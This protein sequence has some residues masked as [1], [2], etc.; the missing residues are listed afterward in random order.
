[1]IIGILGKAGSGKDTVAD[2]LVN[3][4]NLV[5]ISFADPIK[6]FC[7]D[8]FDFSEEQL[9]GPSEFRNKIDDRYG[10]PPREPLQ[11]VGTE[12]IRYCYE[13]AWVEYAIRKAKLLMSN[14]NLR[15]SKSVGVYSI[16]AGERTSDHKPSPKGVVIADCRFSNEVTLVKEAGGILIKV[17]RDGAGLTGAA[18]QHQSET[19]QDGIPDSIFDYTIDNNSTLDAL[20][21]TVKNIMTNLV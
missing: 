2:M 6:R 20:E 11:R 3:N 14:P 13:N 18:A 4:H 5:K 21:N 1:M 16:I 15:Y 10:I 8:V 17:N 12:G 19:E 7:M 9:W